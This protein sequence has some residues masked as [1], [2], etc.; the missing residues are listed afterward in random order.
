MR[1]GILPDTCSQTSTFNNHNLPAILLPFQQN[2]TKPSAQM[3]EPTELEQAEPTTQTQKTSS[4]SR[5]TARKNKTKRK[6]NHTSKPPH[7]RRTLTLRRP[8]FSYVHLQHLSPTTISSS[9]QPPLDAV[10]AHLHLTTALTQFLGLH[11]SAMA[12][13]ILKLSGQEIWIRVQ[14]TDRRA[15]VAAVGGWV[16]ANGEGWRVKGWSE[17]NASANGKEDSCG[18]DLFHD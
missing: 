12:F 18:Q 8:T 17:W 11:G 5:S 3:E 10:T 2:Q 9:Q 16:S 1:F 6:A 14:S 7:I 13:D 15:I 4:S